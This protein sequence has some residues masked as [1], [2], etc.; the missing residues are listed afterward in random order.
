MSTS[1]E[2]FKL[3]FKSTGEEKAALLE[4]FIKDQSTSNEQKLK[5]REER[6]L[7]NYEIKKWQEVLNDIAI[8]E[9]TSVLCRTL[10]ALKFKAII[11]DQCRKVRLSIQQMINDNSSSDELDTLLLNVNQEK[12]DDFLDGQTS[13]KPSQS[14][15]KQ[16]KRQKRGT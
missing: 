1:D 7:I 5:Y 9:R 13:T 16:N 11:Q 8:I 14:S 4:K 6:V 10:S 3:V 15:T 12:V 2:Q